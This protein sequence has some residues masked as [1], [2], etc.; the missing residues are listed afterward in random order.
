MCAN[1]DTPLLDLVF[2]RIQKSEGK[3]IPF[4][5]YLE[6]VLYHPTLGYYSEPV[7]REVGRKGD[8]FTSVSVGDTYG[9]LLS[10]KIREEWH[11]FPSRNG[12]IRIVEQGAHDGRLALDILS[13]LAE[14][15][16][17]PE[18]GWE[19]W[20]VEPRPRVRDQLAKRFREERIPISGVGSVTVAASLEE[21]SGD[22]GIFLCNEL[23][24][25][26]P[27]D[28][29]VRAKEG[30]RELQVAIVDEKLSWVSRPLGDRLADLAS[31]LP[32]ELAEGYT[33][34]L[35]PAAASWIRD[36][37]GLFR[38]GVW[39]IVDYGFEAGDYHASHRTSG[40]FRCYRDHR[41]SEDPFEAPGELDITAHVD[42]SRLRAAGEAAGLTW[43]GLTDQHHFLT[44][45]ARPWLL[46]LEGSA[47][48]RGVAK[49]LRQFQ[50]LTHPGMMGR[51]FKV[52]SFRR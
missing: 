34:E 8:F 20:I 43:E 37:A 28:R 1:K 33:T 36:A 30:W 5:E 46:S 27:F 11:R 2:Q 49:R 47:P 40:T 21:A 7:H 50:T 4:S 48:D 24:D 23:L 13:A 38:E 26:F 45:A 6:L 10:Q 19:Y 14:G 3:S 31:E 39:W 29:V 17:P 22:A 42:F 35:C 18:C 25:A 44:E 41:A 12:P 32:V 15:G 16:D 9:F 52:A 51:Q